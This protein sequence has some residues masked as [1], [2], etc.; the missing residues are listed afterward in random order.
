MA[1]N[2][3]VLSCPILGIWSNIRY[4][5]LTKTIDPTGKFFSIWE[6]FR[7]IV[8]I[9]YVLYV[10]LLMKFL[11]RR[12]NHSNTIIVRCFDSILT[13]DMYVRLHVQYYDERGIQITHPLYTAYHY[14]TTSFFIDV[15]C[16]LPFDDLQL[17]RL[18]GTYRKQHILMLMYI[19]IKPLTLHRVFN[20]LD[21]V[22]EVAREGRARL[23]Q[24]FKYFGLVV[25]VTLIL[26]SILEIVTCGTPSSSPEVFY[27]CTNETWI[28]QAISKAK[29]NDLFYTPSIIAIYTII[30][31]ISTCTVGLY[32]FE[33]S[34][35]FVVIFMLIP[36][37]YALRWF[38]LGKITSSMV[39]KLAN[40]TF[41]LISI[42]RRLAETTL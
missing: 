42:Y 23:Y 41:N 37:L 1:F 35:D 26:A 25:T 39:L 36:G 16:V 29:I 12:R 34:K 15:L 11:L 22:Q 7:G 32:T 31:I 24:N 21:Y 2:L 13:L 3:V 14:L 4:F 18:F 27:N 10:T 17:H 19:L 20:G 38:L 5:L 8:S 9:L 33:T 40:L 6:I 30:S 28:K